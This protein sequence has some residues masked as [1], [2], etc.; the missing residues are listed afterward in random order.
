M[1]KTK[2]E[3][4]AEL[5]EIGRQRTALHRQ[6][7]VYLEELERLRGRKGA[8]EENK[9]YAELKGH[10]SRQVRKISDKLNDLNVRDYVITDQ[11]A[12]ELGSREV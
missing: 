11:L 10:C 1:K 8:S 4:Q 9:V 12:K 3:L 2:E 5:E 6:Q 7:A